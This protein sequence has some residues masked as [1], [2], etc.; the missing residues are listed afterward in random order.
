M[1]EDDDEEEEGVRNGRGKDA[2]PVRKGWRWREGLL[3]GLEDEDNK[4]EKGVRR[5][6]RRG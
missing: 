4:D 3:V 5:K 6:G 1:K 2:S